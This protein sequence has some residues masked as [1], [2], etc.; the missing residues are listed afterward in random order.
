[1]EVILALAILAGALVVLGEL[2]RQGL[3]YAE[4]ARDVTQAQMLC[5]SKLAE[6]CSSTTAP[7]A[8]TMALEGDA[9]LVQNYQCSVEVKSLSQMGLLAVRVTVSKTASDQLRPPVEVALTR[10]M[11]DPTATFSEQSTTDEYSN[12]QETQQ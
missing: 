4:R 3:H 12:M 2:A 5:E 8:G 6:L 9:A 10:W 11:V 1:L 7:T